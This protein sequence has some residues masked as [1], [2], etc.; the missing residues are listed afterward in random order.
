MKLPRISAT[1]TRDAVNVASVGIL[2]S[3]L[4]RDGLSTDDVALIGAVATIPA[5]LF[6]LRF[7]IAIVGA[8]LGR[9]GLSS[10]D[11]ALLAGLLGARAG[12]AHVARTRARR[13]AAALDP[14]PPAPPA[15]RRRRPKPPGRQEGSGTQEAAP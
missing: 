11:A 7:A 12:L 1:A 13:A 2:A 3:S 14:P 8:W 6:L 4:V 9:D 10:D 5:G 15:P